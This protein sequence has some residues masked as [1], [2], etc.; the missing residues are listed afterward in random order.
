LA[1]A[2]T[3]KEM[4]FAQKK[5]L[6]IARFLNRV[7]FCFF[8]EDTGLLPKNL[9]SDIAKTGIDDPKLFAETLEKLFAVMAKGGTF[10]KDKI[11][12]FNGHLFEDSTVFELTEAELRALATAGEA[13]WQF[14]EPSIMGTLFERALDENQRSQLGAHYTSEADI[15]T[16]VEPVL[17]APDGRFLG[18]VGELIAK[19]F[20]RMTLNDTQEKGHDAV[21]AEVDAVGKEKSGRKVEVK[22]RSRSTNIEFSEVPEMVLVIYVSPRTLKWGEVCYGSGAELLTETTGAKK[23]ENG[24]IRTNCHKLMEAAKRMHARS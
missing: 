24:K 1:D 10:G 20:Y 16:L 18:D 19:I 9:F 2:R 22:L 3:R 11:R 15:R 23:L 17:M 12:Y 14:I 13:D 5:N 4:N 21:E 6:R 7:V 8:A